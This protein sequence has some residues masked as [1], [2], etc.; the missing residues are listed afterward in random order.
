[1]NG[2]PRPHGPWTIASSAVV[3]ADPWIHVRLDQVIRPDGRPGTHT[4]TTIKPGVC[5]IAEDDAGD[6]ILTSEFHYAVGR[7]TLEGVSGGCDGD[8]PPEQAARRELAEELGLVAGELVPLGLCDPFTAMVLSPTHLFAARRLSRGVARPEGTER[9]EAVR[10]P[11]ETAVER[12]MNSDIT[13]GPTCVAILKWWR[14]RSATRDGGTSATEGQTS[15]GRA[16]S[17]D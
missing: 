17:G 4:V 16:A 6:V 7:V 15:F 5:V 2:L 13:H 12:V 14:I 11:L 10:M 9:I 3:Y 8:E 1:M